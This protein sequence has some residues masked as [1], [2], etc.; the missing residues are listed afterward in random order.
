MINPFHTRFAAIF[1][2]EFLLNAKRVAPYALMVLFSATA[3]MCWGKGPAVALG[4]ATNSDFYIVRNLKAFSFLLGLP[5]FNAVIMGDPVIRDFR[6]GIDSLIFS[7]PVG[8]ASYILG[9]FF[10]NF[11]VLVCCMSAFMLTMLVLQWFPS[12]RLVV[13]PLRVFP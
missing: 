4:W 9:K 13:L 8:R 11:F 6:A 1:Q 10:G 3:V 2:N 12:S 5:I 7:K